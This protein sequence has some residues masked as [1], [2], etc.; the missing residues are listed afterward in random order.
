M[1]VTRDD[2]LYGALSILQPVRGPRVN[3]D[4]ILLAA[5]VR[6]VFPREG[7]EKASLLELGCASGTVSLL[8]AFRFP[9]LRSIVGVDIQED[10]VGLARRNAELNGLSDRVSFLS[11]DLRHV[12]HIF[13]PQSFDCVVMNP[14]YEEP[15]RGRP[16]SAPGER[17]ARQGECCSLAEASD[18]FRYLLRNRGRLFLVFKAGRAGELLSVLSQRGIEPKR[19][20]FVHPLPGRKASV[21]LVEALRGG[22]PGMTVE[23]PLFIED[24]KGEYTDALL[25]AYTKEGLPCLCS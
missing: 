2:V 19:C 18:A 3:V 9:F 14:P 1:T 12:R 23:P 10:L 25:K 21:I 11:G 13:P 16:R 20:R 22:G 24:G 7:K 15:G 5:Y 6:D 8:L 17:Q 4:T